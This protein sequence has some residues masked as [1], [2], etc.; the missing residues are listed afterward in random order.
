ML[1]TLLAVLLL[2]LASTAHA[3]VAANGAAATNASAAFPASPVTWSFT[4]PSGANSALTL[5]VGIPSGG[6]PGT[7]S[8]VTYG[9]QAMTQQV[10]MTDTTPF[11]RM[12]QFT[13]V[14][15]PTGSNSF[16]IAFTGNAQ[17]IGSSAP[18]V[19]VTS[20]LGEWGLDCVGMTS[21]NLGT[22]TQAQDANFAV[23]GGTIGGS[24][25]T[26]AASI[27]FAWSMTGTN[28]WAQTAISLQAAPAN[29]PSAAKRPQIRGRGR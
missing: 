17:S 26:G 29:G 2:G 21:A 8:S 10:T 20:T 28:V 14:N 23:T 19:A 27:T 16:S 22:P 4:M 24:D 13:L 3:A 7:I 15:P 25:A 1:V 6:S 5:C 9:G 12:Y 11:I 18:S